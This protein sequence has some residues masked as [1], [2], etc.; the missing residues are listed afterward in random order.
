MERGQQLRSQRV[1]GRFAP[2]PSGPLHLGNLRTA[3]LSWL[4]ARLQRGLWLLRIDDLDTPRIRPGATESVLNDLQWLGLHWDGPV[5]FQSQRRGLYGSFL[6][7]LRRQNL[8]YACRCSRRQ[9]A[10][11]S[12]YPGTCRGQGLSWGYDDGRLPAW[13]LTAPEPYASSCGDPVVRRADG[14]VAYHLATVV[15]EL[16]LGITHVVRGEDL[17]VASSAHQ[18][19]AAVLDQPSPAYQHVP[20][21]LTDGGDKLSKRNQDSGI[22]PLKVLGWGPEQLVGQLASSLQLVPRGTHLSVNELLE[23]LR[24][25][26]QRLRVLLRVATS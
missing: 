18:A 17:I 6:S 24:M 9:L 11:I 25:Q 21:L 4:H 19:V 26:P 7:A 10:G 14:F 1:C 23:D 20:L 22:A 3:L 2:T 15:D 8:I 12:R 16:T 5:V 13:R